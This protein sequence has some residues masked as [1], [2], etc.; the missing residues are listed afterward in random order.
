MNSAS[1]NSVVVV[2]GVAVVAE[3]AD[4]R[5]DIWEQQSLALHFLLK[6]AAVLPPEVVTLQ[7]RHAAVLRISGYYCWAHGL[8]N[9]KDT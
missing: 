8:I 1:G 5:T 9:Y 7:H 4:I 2:S 6:G 3:D